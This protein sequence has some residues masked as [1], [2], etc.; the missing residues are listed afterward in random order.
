[1]LIGY[2]RVSS[3]EQETTLQRD[4]L[5]RAGVRRVYEEKRSAVKKRPALALA[6]SSLEPGQTLVVYKVDRLARSLS[7]LLQILDAVDTAGASFKSLT[8]PIDTSSPAGRMTLQLLGAFAEFERAMIRERSMAGQAAA[9]QRGARIGRPR[10]LSPKQQ[11]AV[12]E[13]LSAGVASMSSLAL[14]YGVHVSTIKRVWLRVAKPDSPAVALRHSL[15]PV[16]NECGTAGRAV[17]SSRRQ[18]GPESDPTAAAE[19]SS[20]DDVCVPRS[21]CTRTL[22]DH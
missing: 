6:L 8:E 4:A 12:Y 20:P 14:R 11:A 5:S 18:C 16:S 21:P 15:S 19:P 1:M 13:A 2:A 7:D 3:T 17:P 22:A 10:A 9:R